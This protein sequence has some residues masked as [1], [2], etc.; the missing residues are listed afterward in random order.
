MAC[1]M[2][3][4]RLQELPRQTDQKELLT[5]P[6]PRTVSGARGTD[7]AGRSGGPVGDAVQARGRGKPSSHE[8]NNGLLDTITEKSAGFL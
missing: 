3:M 5:V 2:S 7:A 4:D 8:K 6:W 1:L